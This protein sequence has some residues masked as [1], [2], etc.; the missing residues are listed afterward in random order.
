MKITCYLLLFF[1][2]ASWSADAQQET[3]RQADV[4][5]FK[6]R[7]KIKELGFIEKEYDN[8]DILFVPLRG[9]SR[10]IK[11]VD[12]LRT[13][14]EPSRILYYSNGR[15]VHG[16]G[17]YLNM[18][19][20]S[21][22]EYNLFGSEDDDPSGLSQG[23]L[24]NGVT[25]QITQ[26][27][28]ANKWLS[29]G[30]GLGF[31]YIETEFFN[32]QYFPLFLEYRA[33]PWGVSQITPMINC[34][35][36]YGFPNQL[37]VSGQDPDEYFNGGIRFGGGIGLLFAR[38]KECQFMFNIGYMGQSVEAGVFSDN[39]DFFGIFVEPKLFVNRIEAG[40]GLFF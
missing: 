36:G 13:E 19:I 32:A 27:F 10:R 3:P 18:Y 34:H 12:I 29:L 21:L 4:V 16:N 6:K 33:M 30:V 35:L 15:R 28:T 26:G 9:I 5:R 2:V 11:E 8:G 22:S 40:F 31:D 14:Q 17:Y 25:L 23:R 38:V 1:L 37:L 39:N 7:G 24:N 20:A